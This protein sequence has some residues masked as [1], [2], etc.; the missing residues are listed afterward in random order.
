MTS[1]VQQIFDYIVEN[2]WCSTSAIAEAVG[3]NRNQVASNVHNG[4]VKRRGCV[5]EYRTTNTGTGLEYVY[6][7]RSHGAAYGRMVCRDVY[8]KCELTNAQYEQL[9]KRLKARSRLFVLNRSFLNNEYTSLP[10]IHELYGSKVDS[11]CFVAGLVRLGMKVHC[12]GPFGERQIK[13]IGYE[14]KVDGRTTKPKK[15]RKPRKEEQP[16][17]VFVQQAGRQVRKPQMDVSDDVAKAL[18]AWR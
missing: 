13:I 3:I 15:P 18:S 16:K 7:L 12:R 5:I 14:H 17:M 4:L 1:K 11:G 9:C 6:K 8:K 2:K 10:Q